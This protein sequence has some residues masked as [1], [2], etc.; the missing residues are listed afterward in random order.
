MG[1]MGKRHEIMKKVFIALVFLDALF[2]LFVPFLSVKIWFFSDEGSESIFIAG[3][4]L[5][6]LVLYRFYV[7]ETKFNKQY[8]DG[9]EE[10]LR[11]TFKYIGSVNLQIE[12]MKKVFSE[13]VRY[14]ESKKELHALF[15]NMAERILGIVNTDWVLLKV[16]DISN[17]STLHDY[18]I[19]RGNKQAERL[20]I[21]N[22]CLLDGSCLINNQT[23]VGSTQENFNIKAFCILPVS[24]NKN[25]EFMIKSIVN[26]LEMMFVI[27][28]S[29]Y[30]K[31][32][33]NN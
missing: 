11:E 8:Q 23:V 27:F 26:Q 21:D 22:Q 32:K 31:K 10:R 15:I 29:L 6:S 2:I 12:E 7:K 9:L 3:L 33:Q 1:Y 19:A 20:K 17:K 4:F 13:N 30:Y 5:L 14:P 25:Q 24:L 28:N 16:V 18:F